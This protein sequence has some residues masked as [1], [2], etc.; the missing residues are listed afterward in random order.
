MPV[1][2]QQPFHVSEYSLLDHPNCKE[3]SVYMYHLCTVLLANSVSLYT[4][5]PP[6]NEIGDEH[7][8]HSSEVVPSLEVEIYGQYKGR[9]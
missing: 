1:N 6:N 3:V 9:G 2:A 7:F 4:V 5:E 8:I